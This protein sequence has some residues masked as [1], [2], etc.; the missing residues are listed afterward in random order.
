MAEDHPLVANWA[1]QFSVYRIYIKNMTARLNFPSFLTG[2]YIDK[3]WRD[4][5]RFNM[6]EVYS[7]I[8]I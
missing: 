7:A 3:N 2:D 1:V 6:A 8:F 4:I 5:G